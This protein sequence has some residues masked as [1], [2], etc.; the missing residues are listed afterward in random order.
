[1]PVQVPKYMYVKSK[2]KEWAA[3]GEIRPGEQ[4]PTEHQLA[5]QFQMSRQ[6]IRMAMNELEHEGV[7]YRVQGRGTFLSNGFLSGKGT[8]IS[9]RIIAVV[10][11]YISDYIFPPIIRGIETRLSQDGYSMLLLS[12]NNDHQKESQALESIL[13]TPIDG[14]ILEP[15][16]SSHYNPNTRKFLSILA[17][18][19]PI[20]ML[21]GSYVELGLP[22]VRLDDEEGGALATEHLH[23]L[24]HKKIGVLMKT[25][26]IQGKL[27]FRGF[28]RMSTR[29]GIDILPEWIRFSS[30]EETDENVSQYAKMI[31]GVKSEER[32]TAL[33]CYNDAL[34]AK[35]LSAFLELGISVPDDLSVLSFDDSHLA[36]VNHLTSVKHPK[37]DMGVKAADRIL[38]SVRIRQHNSKE[39]VDDYIYPTE[40]SIRSSTKRIATHSPSKMP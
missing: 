29:M 30:T 37:Y 31:A 25:D 36:E 21:H 32:P 18:R 39:T 24:G 4:V 27:R 11:T 14:I 35:L 26:D 13:Q 8:D 38:T 3:T 17:R 19:I 1:M 12:T 6:T 33:L 2:I 34:A 5:E 23:S 9:H 40:L 20:V 10:T 16:K 7:L 15:T 28:M 22:C